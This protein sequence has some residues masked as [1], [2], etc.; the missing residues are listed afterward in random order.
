MTTIASID[1]AA[2][3]KKASHIAGFG[4][5][6]IAIEPKLLAECGVGCGSFASELGDFKPV[7]RQLSTA[8]ERR[9]K[10]EGGRG[11]ESVIRGVLPLRL[12]PSAFNFTLALPWPR[13]VV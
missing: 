8:A 11:K 12:S 4:P 2:G 10:G 13:L 6:T 1:D 3:L 7:A 5:A 9:W